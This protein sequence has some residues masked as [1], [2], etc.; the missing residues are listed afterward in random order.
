VSWTQRK[1]MNELDQKITTELNRMA[2]AVPKGLVD[3]GAEVKK[4][5]ELVIQQNAKVLKKAWHWTLGWHA[6]FLIAAVI[7][8]WPILADPKSDEMPAGL[9]V[10]TAAL[11]GLVWIKVWYTLTSTRLRLE[12]KL[13]ELELGIAEVKELLKSG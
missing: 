11:A 4:V 2:E 5:M 1:T 8:I 13:K 12:T 6:F 10:A 3:S 9:F 7:G